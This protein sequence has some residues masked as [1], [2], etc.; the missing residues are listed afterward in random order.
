M[1]TVN[2]YLKMLT[3]FFE[4][5]G[6]INTV[7]VGD[8]YDFNAVPNIIYPVVNI[9]FVRQNISPT[10]VNDQF[11]ITV[12]D[13]F[14]PN[15]KKSEYAMYSDSNLIADDTITYFG[16]QYDVDF[17]ISES[18]SVQKWKG[19]VDRLAGCVFVLSFDQFRVANDCILPVNI[20]VEPF[21]DG[22]SD[23][24]GIKL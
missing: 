22:F 4:S 5:H 9:E 15:I 17:E 6:Q 12:A 10:N 2:Q 20:I 24:F 14:D 21:N 18:T 11:E 13:L 16:N 23:E 1:I 3:D 8:N 19:N 7:L